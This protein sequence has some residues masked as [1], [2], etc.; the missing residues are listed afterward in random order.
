MSKWMA[1]PSSHSIMCSSCHHAWVMVIARRAA[2]HIALAGIV[3][4]L[5]LV[6]TCVH[7]ALHQPYRSSRISHTG[8]V[9]A[10][11]NEAWACGPRP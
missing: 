5:P 7:V 3:K 10:L 9:T 2:S 1:F 4:W 11:G 8:A 6:Y